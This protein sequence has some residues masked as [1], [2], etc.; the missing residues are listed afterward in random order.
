V[1]S[2]TLGPPVGL[3]VRILPG[4]MPDDFA[5]HARTIAYNLD[6][7]EVRVIPLGP[8]LI[9]LEL[10]PKPDSTQASM[11]GSEASHRLRRD[12]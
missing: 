7:A 10:L 5:A 9:R 12:R 4:Q 2:V 6:V 11:P 8:D 3:D 1:V